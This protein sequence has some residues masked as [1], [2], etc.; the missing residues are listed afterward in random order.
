M[1][2][3]VRVADIEQVDRLKAYL[4]NLFDAGKYDAV[5]RAVGMHSEL[6]DPEH[7]LA[8]QASLFRYVLEILK[9]RLSSSQGH[10]YAAW[11]RCFPR[12]LDRLLETSGGE[13]DQSSRNVLAS[14]R[15]AY[16]PFRSLDDF[17]FWALDDRRLTLAQIIR[18][19]EKTTA[20]SVC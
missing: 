18:L 19:I 15:A 2:T 1:P 17:Y 20:I 10:A 12:S 14:H 16:G 5:S 11:Y 6:S 13:L 7:T 3:L 4:Q 9:H 8:D